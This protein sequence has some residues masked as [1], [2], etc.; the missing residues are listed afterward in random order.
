MSEEKDN[1]DEETDNTTKNKS[2][3][4]D[5]TDGTNKNECSISKWYC[6][7]NET[8]NSIN[9]YYKE[10]RIQA[11]GLLLLS[12]LMCAVG[13]VLFVLCI[14]SS[15]QENKVHVSIVVFGMI[16]GIVM[17]LVAGM[18][19]GGYKQTLR[20][21]NVIYDRM[22]AA[23]RYTLALRVAEALPDEKDKNEAYKEIIEHALQDVVQLLEGIDEN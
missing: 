1:V 23:D 3:T 16:C 4:F 6:N 22:V 17:Q 18:L 15:V 11:R 9:Q 19:F 10:T 12:I 7:A 2:S 14:N 13:V 5:K 20:E 8:N 21:L